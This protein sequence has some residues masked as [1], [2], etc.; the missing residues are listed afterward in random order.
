[1]ISQSVPFAKGRGR[2]TLFKINRW[3]PE[4]GHFSKQQAFPWRG[5]AGWPVIPC[6]RHFHI[7]E[8]PQNTTLHSA[9]RQ[10][11]TL[12]VWQFSLC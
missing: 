1:M 6:Q 4:S 10:S 7:V 12:R 2:R 3:E 5:C 11:S 8:Q 9:D